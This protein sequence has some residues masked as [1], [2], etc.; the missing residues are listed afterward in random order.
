[1]SIDIK[2]VATLV[3]G[4]AAMMRKIPHFLDIFLPPVFQMLF[5]LEDDPAWYTA[6]DAESSDDFEVKTNKN[7][8]HFQIC[9]FRMEKIYL[10]FLILIVP[11]CRCGRRDPGPSCNT[12]GRRVLGPRNI[13]NVAPVD[14]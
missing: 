12:H 11:E 5:E 2:V 7:T 6:S 13:R 4:N 14:E 8:T 10:V 9:S 3:E 1:M